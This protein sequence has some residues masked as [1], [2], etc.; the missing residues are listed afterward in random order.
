MACK[1]LIDKHIA[2]VRVARGMRLFGW[3]RAAE[4]LFH[5]G[6]TYYS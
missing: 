1:Q 5:P 6:E 3:M 2:L 4:E